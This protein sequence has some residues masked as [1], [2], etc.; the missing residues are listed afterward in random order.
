MVPTSGIAKDASVNVWHYGIVTPGAE[1]ATVLGIWQTFM[2]TF[3]NLFPSTV[4]QTG[5]TLRLYDLADPE[6]RAPYYTGS[7]SFATAPS[8]T[9]APPECAMVVSF[10][11]ERISGQDQKRRRGRMYMGPLDASTVGSGLFSGG[12]VSSVATNVKS[13]CDDLE[14]ANITFGV[15]SRVDNLLVTVANGWVDNNV[16]IQRRR[17]LAATSRT[18]W[19]KA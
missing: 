7:W 2:R 8:G 6:P 10:Q 14:T 18:T 5:H 11:G 9:S 3:V 1:G 4:A 15:Y 19:A 17:G 13:L 12:D 16:D